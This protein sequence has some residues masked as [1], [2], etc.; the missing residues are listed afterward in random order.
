MNRNPHHMT[1]QEI[2]EDI[3]ANLSEED[4]EGLKETKRHQ[5]IRFHHGAG[6]AIRNRYGLHDR[7]IEQRSKAVP[8]GAWMPTL[9]IPVPDT[10]A[11][12]ESDEP[13]KFPEW[14]VRA[15]PD[16]VSMRIIVAVW[17]RLQA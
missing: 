14:E 8:A 13:L 9:V 7:P 10:I 5:L 12:L 1:E 3:L 17:E 6:T 11:D 4:R 15:D 2:V 16:A